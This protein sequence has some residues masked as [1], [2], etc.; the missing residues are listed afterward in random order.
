MSE[1]TY[2]PRLDW[3]DNALWIL[4]GLKVG[5]LKRPEEA[6][7]QQFIITCDCATGVEMLDDDVAM[8]AKFD[9]EHYIE[10]KKWAEHR[11]AAP[12]CSHRDAYLVARQTKSYQAMA[13]TLY[14]TWKDKDDA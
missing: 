4:S 9:V 10:E 12:H 14:L 8:Y 2:D 7:G 5:W 11:T 3:D 13:M 6:G 1:R